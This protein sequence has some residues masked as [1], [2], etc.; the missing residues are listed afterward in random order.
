M[1]MI[2]FLIRVVFPDQGSRDQKAEFVLRGGVFYFFL[3]NRG[4]NK[5]V[6]ARV[7][8]CVWVREYN[9]LWSK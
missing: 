2:E 1:R 9:I 3:F 4:K 8:E 5:I 7:L 6:L